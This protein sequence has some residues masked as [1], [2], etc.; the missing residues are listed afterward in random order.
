MKTD[1]LVSRAEHL[2]ESSMRI[3]GHDL[4]TSLGVKTHESLVSQAKELAD[5]TNRLLLVIKKRCEK[6]GPLK[7]SRCLLTCLR[8]S[9]FSM[10]VVLG[11]SST[12]NN[13][14][15]LKTVGNCLDLAI[16]ISERVKLAALSKSEVVSLFADKI[17]ASFLVRLKEVV[18]RSGSEKLNKKVVKLPL[19]ETTDDASILY[20]CGMSPC[21]SNAN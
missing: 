1:A 17:M 20:S 6:P 12:R 4:S 19:C 15:V 7:D 18:N 16:R 8:W 11:C 9:L 21:F 14:T 13:E 3:V 2:H 5:E 10:T